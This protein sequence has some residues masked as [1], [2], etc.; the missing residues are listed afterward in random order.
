MS[1]FVLVG[2]VPRTQLRK[3]SA[4]LSHQ[5]GDTVLPTAHDIAMRLHVRKTYVVIPTPETAGSFGV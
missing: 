1:L 4:W 2:I 3:K 5:I